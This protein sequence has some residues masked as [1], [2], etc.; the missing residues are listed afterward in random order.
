MCAC[1]TCWVRCFIFW[2]RVS[3][4][5][6]LPLFCCFGWLVCVLGPLI[7]TQYWEPASVL[8]RKC[9]LGT[10]E[11]WCLMLTYRSCYL[12]LM[13]G[14]RFLFPPNHLCTCLPEKSR[15]YVHRGNQRACFCA[16]VRGWERK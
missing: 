14:Q 9:L 4:P 12:F 15:R 13:W 8:W 6:V 11:G 16:R 7:C 2:Y 10:Y 1:S 3:F 5:S